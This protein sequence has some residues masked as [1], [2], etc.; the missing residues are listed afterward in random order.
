M[1]SALFASLQEASSTATS[2]MRCF[3]LLLCLLRW[4]NP[5][6]SCL[7]SGHWGPCFLSPGHLW[8]CFVSLNSLHFFFLKQFRFIAKLNWR[9]RDS[10]WP[11][12]TMASPR[13]HILNQMPHS[14]Q[15]VNLHWQILGLTLGGVHPMGLDKCIRVCIHHYRLIQSLL[16]ALKILYVSP[17]HPTTPQSLKT[18]YLYSLYNFAFSRMLQSWN[19]TAW[20]LFRLA[21]LTLSYAFKVP[22]CLFVAWF[23]HWI[24]SHC[25]ERPQFI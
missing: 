9:Y 5:A 3:G 1:W 24:I 16:I 13:N 12:C 25:L 20:R 10:P 11:L 19:Y 8:L 4:C 17:L 18:T 6:W 23:Y 7:L 21:S 14:F 2:W 22:P 15:S